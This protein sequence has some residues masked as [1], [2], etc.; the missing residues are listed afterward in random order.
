M[1]SDNI[2]E[3]VNLE[4]EPDKE[5]AD[6]VDFNGYQDMMFDNNSKQ[7]DIAAPRKSSIWEGAAG[8]TS[9]LTSVFGGGFGSSK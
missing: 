9:S 7:S 5:G 3:K 2:F 1:E 4:E 8:L 6:T